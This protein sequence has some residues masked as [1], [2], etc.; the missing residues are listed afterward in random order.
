LVVLRSLL[1]RDR[2]RSRK[3][4]DNDS[5]L[6]GQRGSDIDMKPSFFPVSVLSSR[7]RG[8]V[9]EVSG[10]SR[11]IATRAIPRGWIVAVF[12]GVLLDGHALRAATPG[13]HLGRVVLQVDEDAYLFSTMDSPADWINH[14]CDPTC[15]LRGQ[16]SLVALRTI[17]P[18][19]E[20]TFDYA[21]ADGSP[22]DE[23]VC[24]CGAPCCRGN[25]RGDDWRR[26]ELWARYDGHFSPYLEKRIGRLSRRNGSMARLR[27]GASSRRSPRA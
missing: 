22:Y 21:T 14:S 12:G 9:G 26:P 19:E 8:E 24:R 2:A 25:I 13:V 27:G 20:L 16:V 23:F 18:G 5:P 4:R 3:R 1:L 10:D 6:V 7:A 15:G 17:A 11:V